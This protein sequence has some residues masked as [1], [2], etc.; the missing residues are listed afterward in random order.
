MRDVDPRHLRC[1]PAAEL[2]TERARLG[3]DQAPEDGAP[4][5]LVCRGVVFCPDGDPP[6]PAHL[7]PGAGG[8]C[9]GDRFAF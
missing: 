2:L 1:P 5:D 6:V 3:P 4:D 9:D 7:P 8:S